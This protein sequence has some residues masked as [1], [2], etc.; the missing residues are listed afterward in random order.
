M[1]KKLKVSALLI[2]L[3]EI[4]SVALDFCGGSNGSTF[5]EFTTGVL[6][7]LSV[8]MKLVGIILLIFYIVKVSKK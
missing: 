6:L 2:I 3:G 7:G 1:I 8:G 5:S 4:L